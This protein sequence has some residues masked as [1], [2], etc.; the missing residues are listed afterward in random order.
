[1]YNVHTSFVEGDDLAAAGLEGGTLVDG[2][3]LVD[4][5]LAGVSS[6]STHQQPA[7]IRKDCY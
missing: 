6:G 3:T 7:Q 5:G 1:M 2:T 4:P